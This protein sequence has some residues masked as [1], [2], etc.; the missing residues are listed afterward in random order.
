MAFLNLALHQTLRVSMKKSVM[1]L[2]IIEK[3]INLDF[4]SSGLCIHFFQNVLETELFSF[5]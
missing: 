3:L 1:F 5:N 4:S 2:I